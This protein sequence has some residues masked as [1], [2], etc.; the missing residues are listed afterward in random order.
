MGGLVVPA[1]FPSS[2]SVDDDYTAGDRTWTWDGEKWVRQGGADTLHDLEMDL[3]DTAVATL[4]TMLTDDALDTLDLATANPIVG[5]HV[6][7]SVLLLTSGTSDTDAS[8]YATASI[9]AKPYSVLLV[10]AVSSHA[11][12]APAITVSGLSG[13]TWTQVTEV[14]HGAASAPHPYRLAVWKG[15]CGATPGTATLTISATSSTSMKHAVLECLATDLTTP[16]AQNAAAGSG[17]A[18]ATTGAVALASTVD[19]AIHSRAI[20]FFHHVA[21][22][23]TT[24]AVTVTGQTITTGVEIVDVTSAAPVGGLEVQVRIRPLGQHG[25][26]ATAV[27]MRSFA[28]TWTTSSRW[29]AIAVEVKDD[30]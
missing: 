12:T 22:E 1:V 13:V 21:A 15:I 16:V 5:D 6:D 20:G 28:A 27:G 8:S 30:I 2:P 19:N 14:Q 23:A 9:V 11:T 7:P 25:T 10:A 29:G 24:P 26:Q 17:S 4:L 3:D 18:T